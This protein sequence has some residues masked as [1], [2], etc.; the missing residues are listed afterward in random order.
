[1]YILAKI[2]AIV[3]AF[4]SETEECMQMPFTG[5]ELSFLSLSPSGPINIDL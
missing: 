1:M 3:D 2:M 4:T 5:R